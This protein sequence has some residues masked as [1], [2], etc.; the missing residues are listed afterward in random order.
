MTTGTVSVPL[1]LPAL[2]SGPQGRCPRPFHTLSFT[3]L[4]FP[5]YMVSGSRSP[6][7]WLGAPWEKEDEML[8][9]LEECRELL[10]LP[11]GG[12]MLPVAGV[13]ASQLACTEALGR[14]AC[15]LPL[16]ASFGRISHL[17]PCVEA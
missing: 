10:A 8:D 5:S 7:P 11:G 2:H 14:A 3:H 17:S 13:P 15:Q 16:K 1:P 4:F 9:I 6:F 12:E